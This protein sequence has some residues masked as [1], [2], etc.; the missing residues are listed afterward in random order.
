MHGA[1]IRVRHADRE[2][3]GALTAVVCVLAAALLYLATVAAWGPGEELLEG[4]SG[5]VAGRAHWVG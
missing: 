3:N 4:S 1:M 2:G 5:T